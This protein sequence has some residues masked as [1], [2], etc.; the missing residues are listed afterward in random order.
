MAGSCDASRKS[1]AG[2]G[3]ARLAGLA[4]ARHD[5]AMNAERKNVLVLSTCQMLFGSCRSLLAATAPLVAY[6][7][8]DDKALATLPTS[9][10]VVGTALATIPAAMTMRRFGRKTGFIAGAVVGLVAGGVC[11]AAALMADFALFAL[12]TFLFGICAGF[13]QLYRFAA[14]DAAQPA[15]RSKAISLVLAGGVVA[16][17]VG[18]ELAKLGYGLLPAPFAGGYALLALVGV[19]TI[20]A[21]LFLNVPAR[22]R[23]VLEGPR[24][25][26][27][28]V[29]AQPAF[30]V[31]T[32]VA[33]IAQGVMSFLM[34]ATPIAMHVCHLSF[35]DTAFVV[36]WHIFA[37]YAPGFVTGLLIARYGEL[38]II[39]AGVLL[40]LVCVAIALSGEGVH[41]FWLSMMLLGLG[42]N[43][44]F[45]AATA[46]LV[47]TYTPAERDATQGA[48]NF[49]IYGFVA[50]LS[51]SSGALVHF[52][53]WNWVNIGALPLLVV[54]GGATLWCAA[55]GV[56]K[57]LARA[58]AP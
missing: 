35:G 12:G 36:E 42:W 54:A 47:Q 29:M 25:P 14:T 40:Q 26:L 5:P 22:T 1:P 9:L 28:V 8:L 56:H 4:R 33:T 37:M 15:Y 16:A 27:R 18:P 58:A 53:G 19:A 46:L 38:V 45:T 2:A 39:M 13:A 32:L 21:L 3:A 34:T 24:R 57:N 41:Q 31:A 17:F 7:L 43:F 51:L 55:N 20:A 49:I 48:T 52:F 6:S 10:I 23:A 44:S 50:A 11:A 30:I